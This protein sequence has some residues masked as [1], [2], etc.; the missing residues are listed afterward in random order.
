MVGSS[1]S[2]TKMQIS[3]VT[4]WRLIAFGIP[5]LIII[6]TAFLLQ[7][8]NANSAALRQLQEEISIQEQAFQEAESFN[9]FVAQ[10]QTILEQLDFALPNE[11]MLVGAVQDIESVIHRF[12]PTATVKL[13]AVTPTRV[14]QELVIPI[15]ITI[16]TPL[17]QLPLLFAQLGELPY[18]IQIISSDTQGVATNATTIIMMRLYV[19]DPFQG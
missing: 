4:K 18:V 19:Q 12:D 16:I 15:T 13:T 1:Q 5:S 6:S 9:R 10:N 2:T 8:A 7:T 11:S 14:G 17:D 3:R